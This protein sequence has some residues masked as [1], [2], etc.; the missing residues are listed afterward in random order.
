LFI[1]QPHQLTPIR[2]QKS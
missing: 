1:L 2:S